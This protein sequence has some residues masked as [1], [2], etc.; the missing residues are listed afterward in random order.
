MI[1]FASSLDQAGSLTQTAEDAALML[2]EMA[3]MDPRDSTSMDV[4]VE[5]YTT[6]L[7]DSLA[8]LTIGLPKELFDNKLEASIETLIASAIKQ[9]EA[10]GA[11]IKEI[12]LPNVN[13]SVPAYYVIAPAE[14]SSNLSRFDGVRYGYRCHD[15]ADLN[16]LYVRSRSEGLGEEVKRRILVGTYALSAGYY[17]AYYR[18][19]QRVRRLIKN[20]FTDAF[21]EVDLML[22]PTAPSTAFKV[23]EKSEDPISMYLSDVFTIAISLAGLPA[24]SIPTGFSNGLPVGLQLIGNYFG[25]SRLLNAAHQYQK[26]TDWHQYVPIQYT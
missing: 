17:D 9:Y 18:K 11:K 3:G 12:S 20:D 22:C 24:L 4:S 6:Q 2:N 10:L 21:K 15:P 13:L 1:A 16:D 19:A 5:D 23:G 25:E 8:G 7:N 14:C 26:V